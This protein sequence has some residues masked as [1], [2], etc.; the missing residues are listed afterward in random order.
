MT[1]VKGEASDV[2]GMIVDARAFDVSVEASR[3]TR[4][5][6]P[7]LILCH[8]QLCARLRHLMKR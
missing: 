6:E 8:V 4:S 5:E 3:K 7:A 1:E 2:M